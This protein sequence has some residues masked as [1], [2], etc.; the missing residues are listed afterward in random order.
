MRFRNIA[1]LAL[2]ATSAIKTNAKSYLDWKEYADE[3]IKIFVQNGG[4][5]NG[6]QYSYYDFDNDGQD[7]LAVYNFHSEEDAHMCVFSIDSNKKLQ[8]VTTHQQPFFYYI[9]D[10]EGAYT[11]GEDEHCIYLINSTA[12]RGED[13]G[14]G[15]NICL[16]FHGR[17]AER[18]CMT[19]GEPLYRLKY[20]PFDMTPY[21]GEVS[22]FNFN[23]YWYRNDPIVKDGV[24]I[25][26]FFNA[27]CDAINMPLLKSAK[28]AVAG[29]PTDNIKT[30]VDAKSGY[31]QCTSGDDDKKMLIECAFW[32]RPNGHHYIALNYRIDDSNDFVWG[33][34]RNLVFWEYDESTSSLKPIKDLVEPLWI[35]PNLNYNIDIELPRKGRDIMI[36]DNDTG[37]RSMMKYQ[38]DEDLITFLQTS[39]H[40]QTILPWQKGLM[41]SVYD[42]SGTPTNI[43]L[44]PGGNKY[45]HT[46]ESPRNLVILEQ[47]KGFFHVIDNMLE[48]WTDECD[49]VM[50]LDDNETG[51]WIHSSCLAVKSIHNNGAPL[52]LLKEMDDCNEQPIIYTIKSETLLRPLEVTKSGWVKVKTLDS[53]Y[54]GWTTKDR[55]GAC[56][57]K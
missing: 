57:E 9:P 32:K 42:T 2:V 47:S 40:E 46:T 28:Y 25:V 54:T 6:A 24:N 13:F 26:S 51:Y 53:K 33:R 16:E 21:D 56:I 31:I 44:T 55:L 30:V 5:T 22:V 17:R 23:L 48:D 8:L 39:V 37:E 10:G 34:F 19:W 12:Q 18:A 50:Y 20:E 29:K 4:N 52:H 35:L 27:I 45:K 3:V 1:M 41:C 14:D 36:T 49:N 15:D 7:E 38:E 43:R 11:I